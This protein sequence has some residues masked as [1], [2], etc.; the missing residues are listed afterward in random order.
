MRWREAW[1]LLSSTPRKTPWG[2]S[3]YSTEDG[4]DEE[5]FA[6]VRSKIKANKT[7][8]DQPPG[9]ERESSSSLLRLLR[10]CLASYSSAD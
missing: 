2:F 4:S 9:E 8:H 10:V 5:A 6:P 1:L 7:F 3:F